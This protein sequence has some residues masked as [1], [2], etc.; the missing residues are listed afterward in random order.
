MKRLRYQ[1]CPGCRMWV[2]KTEGCQN[3][4]CKCGIYFCYKCGVEFS[5]DPCR[6]QNS[7]DK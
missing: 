1:R 6:K 5:Q 7:W 4:S 2:E 3:A